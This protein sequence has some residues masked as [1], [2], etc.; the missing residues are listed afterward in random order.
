[1]EEIVKAIRS[2]TVPVV[3]YI[4]PPGAMAASAGTVV[5]LAAHVA[6]MA[7]ETSIGAASPVSSEGQELGELLREAISRLHPRYST[8]ATLVYLEGL[9]HEETSKMLRIPLGTV[10]SRTD[11]IKKLLTEELALESRVA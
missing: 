4:A 5:T 8:V 10:K 6:A 1:M 7:P 11:R 3:V 2:A 9:S